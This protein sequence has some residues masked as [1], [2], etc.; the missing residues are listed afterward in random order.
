VIQ[1]DSYEKNAAGDVTLIVASLV[2]NTLG[3]D[4]E[5][6]DKPKGVVHWVSASHGK[7]ATV[8]VYD[9]LFN[10]AS[11]DRGDENFMSYVNPESL[12][13]LENCWV[14][15][16]LVDTTPEQGFQFER[17]GYFVA[18]RYDHS[19]ETPVFNKTIGL[20]DTWSQ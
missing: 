12:V 13:V 17:E 9:R 2:P 19:A 16:S 20:R 11:P 5:D 15:P 4:P 8:R 7:R 3:V 18:D 14:E 10:H 6:G 1:A